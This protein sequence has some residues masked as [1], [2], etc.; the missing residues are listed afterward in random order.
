MN[1]DRR[2]LREEPFGGRALF[3]C[4]LERLAQL[5]SGICERLE[6]L[7]VEPFTEVSLH[8]SLLER[9]RSRSMRA[10]SAMRK[11]SSNL[12]F[13]LSFHISP[14]LLLILGLEVIHL[15]DRGDFSVVGRWP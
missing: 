14:E 10:D 15:R 5:R 3:L 2:S 6:P 12:I 11:R 1:L 4:L 9:T 7:H 8:P 13:R